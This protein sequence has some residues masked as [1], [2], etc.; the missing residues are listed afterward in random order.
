MLPWIS[1][2]VARR[3]TGGPLA[4]GSSVKSV[5]LNV[6]SRK[7]LSMLYHTCRLVNLLSFEESRFDLLGS[8]LSRLP[9]LR[10]VVVATPC[11]YYTSRNHRGSS[12]VVLFYH[13][14]LEMIKSS[15]SI[16]KLCVETPWERP[17]DF[18]DEAESFC[19]LNKVF[20]TT[21]LLG[22]LCDFDRRVCFG[23][24]VLQYAI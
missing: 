7:N 16:T 23:F 11:Y 18:Y 9:K 3:R 8:S 22:R 14:L 2:K 20:G 21:N 24:W 5:S 17:P 1:I 10:T 4:L 6:R 19:L 15:N 12:H 13:D